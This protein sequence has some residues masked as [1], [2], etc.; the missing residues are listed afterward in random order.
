MAA[1]EERNRDA[2]ERIRSLMF[3]FEDLSKLD[4][5]GIQTLLSATDKSQLGLAMKGASDTL[6]SLF[7]ANMSER[8]A[9][10]LK[11]DMAAMGPVR[12]KDV[13]EA[14]SAMVRLAKDLAERGDIMLADGGGGDELVY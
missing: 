12:M 5:G 7:F 3:V 14:Q 1:L 6:R 8:A 4:P 2:A 10:I 11:E 9:K 13:D